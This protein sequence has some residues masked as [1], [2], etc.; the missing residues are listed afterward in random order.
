MLSICAV[1]PS[2]RLW[3]AGRQRDLAGNSTV[4]TLLSVT[5][6][7][8]VGDTVAPTVAIVSP[9]NGSTVSQTVKIKTSA[10]DNVQVRKVEVYVDGSKVGSATCS[11]ASCTPSFSWNAKSASKGLHMLWAKAYDATGNLAESSPVSVYRW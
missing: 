9:A 11:S 2:H 5:V 1:P 10:K 3:R 6:N 4:S 7:N 8:V